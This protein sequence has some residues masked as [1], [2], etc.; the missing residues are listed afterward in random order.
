MASRVP[1]LV[2]LIAVTCLSQF[3]RVS[4]SVIAPELVRDLD[5]TARQLGWAGSAFFFALFAVQIPV[6][7]W[8]DRF[9]AR[10]TVAALSIVAMMGALWIAVATDATGLI[11]GRAVVGVGCAASFMSVVFLCSRWFPP[12]RLA[13]VLSWV[14]A[15]SNIGTLAAAT[16]LAWI[17]ATVGWR[18]G[19]AGLAAL[20][21]LVAVSFYAFVRDRPPEVPAP[22]VKKEGL[23]EI[24]KGLLEVW[25]TPGLAPVL[26]MHFFA[27]AT[28]L[29]VL[30][31]W[32]GPYLYDVHKLDAVARGNVLLAMGLAQ[33]L[34]ILAY[35]PMD[36]LLRSRKKVVLGGA[37]ISTALLALLALLPQPPLWL[38]VG[39]LS[40]FCFFCAFGTVIVA[41]GRALFPDRLAGRGVTTVNMAQCLGLAV[42]PAGMGY[43][44]EAFGAGDTAYRIAFAAL[45]CG[46]VLGVSVY[47]RSRDSATAHG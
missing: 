35:G 9:G 10:R 26:A 19:F 27:Y 36:R 12:V 40:A 2:L 1:L 38:A 37:V 31:V 15:A 21:V 16:P 17:A 30:G 8:F 28:M 32:G 41:Q 43:L 29:T 44:I 47:L 25:T 4:N 20:T 39:L 23:G 46:L 45:G 7:M 5:L 34:G 42:L 3:Y 6:G 11:G 22:P 33:I 13:T 18:A 14:F 24:V